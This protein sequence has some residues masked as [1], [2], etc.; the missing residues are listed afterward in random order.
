MRAIKW[1]GLKFAIGGSTNFAHDI[2]GICTALRERKT[3]KRP[4]L[5]FGRRT[6][7]SFHSTHSILTQSV[8]PVA[9]DAR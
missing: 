2:N 6:Y 5:T 7:L 8:F 9:V 3:T 4:H 1:L